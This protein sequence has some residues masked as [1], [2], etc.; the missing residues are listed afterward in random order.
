MFEINTQTELNS[1]LKTQTASKAN[2]RTRAKSQPQKQTR[3]HIWIYTQIDT[4]INKNDIVYICRSVANDVHKQLDEHSR[5]CKRIQTNM[6]VLLPDK[7][8]CWEYVSELRKRISKS[9]SL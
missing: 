9:D 5:A 6:I 3:K 4:H 2:V 8:M 7:Y 1:L